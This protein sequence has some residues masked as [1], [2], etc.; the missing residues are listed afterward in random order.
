MIC[1]KSKT[2]RC[3]RVMAPLI[4]NGDVNMM[5]AAYF[6]LNCFNVGGTCWKSLLGCSQSN[7]HTLIYRS[8]SWFF[9]KRRCQQV[10]T[11]PLA[12]LQMVMHF[13][14]KHISSAAPSLPLNKLH[15]WHQNLL[16]PLSLPSESRE[17]ALGCHCSIS[18]QLISPISPH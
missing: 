18:Q 7:D 14:Q 17:S 2:D 16:N 5:G 4:S 8:S 15:I 12:I 1:Y 9:I 3:L 6:S 10:D 13:Q 11:A